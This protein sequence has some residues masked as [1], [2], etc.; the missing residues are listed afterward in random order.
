MRTKTVAEEE[1]G[2]SDTCLF[3]LAV[4]SSL[5]LPMG[6]LEGNCNKPLLADK[7]DCLVKAF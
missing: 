6:K 2:Q 1:G 5:H 7:A 3:H 4:I